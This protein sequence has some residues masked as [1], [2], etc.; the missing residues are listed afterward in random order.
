MLKQPGDDKDDEDELAAAAAAAAPV[1]STGAPRAGAECDLT[2]AGGRTGV[3]WA[4]PPR[5][6]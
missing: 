2:L 4:P 5:G 6:H 3:P 1:P